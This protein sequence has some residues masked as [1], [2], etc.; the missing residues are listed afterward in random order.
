MNRNFFLLWQGQF[1]SSLGGHVNTIA[2]VA[3]VKHGT[4]SASLIG[5][6]MM[7]SSITRVMLSGIGGVFVDRHSR[8]RII[9]YSDMLRGIAVLSLA[10]LLY[11]APH[12]TGTIVIWLWGVA[13]CIA[14]T[15]AFFAPAMSAAIPELV[16]QDKVARANSLR[17]LTVQIST[18]VGQSLGGILFRL[19]GAPLL[20]L[21]NGLSFLYSAVSESFVTI[22][23][24]IP[25]ENGK[26]KEQVSIY[27]QEIIKGSLYIWNISALKRLLFVSAIINIFS[28]PIIILLPFY[29]EDYLKVKL[30]WYGFFLAIHSVGSVMG[31]LSAGF[32]KLKGE[33]RM[34]IMLT[35]MI[36][37]SLVIAL[38]GF[39]HSPIVA[40]VFAF[41]L[42]I[43]SGFNSTNIV[44][45]LQISTPSEMRGRIFGF[46]NT[47]SGST[48]PLGMG[49]GGIV[50]DL[51]G[52]NIPLVYGS[53]GGI[54]VVLSILVS[55]NQEFRGFLAY[56]PIQEKA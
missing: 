13:I 39:T 22:P 30:D 26:W 17:Q 10:G 8:R 1:V 7:V 54:M 35:F 24:T 28:A 44:T 32:I 36:F 25:D 23:Q 3:L 5:L 46:L 37:N 11:M 14:V 16:P 34:E 45:I 53:C 51:T 40:L 19:L 52:Q 55:M 12:A 31:S 56:E 29:V 38:F 49:L 6:V 21:I 15:S 27:K 2:L 48:V 18:S 43:M 20:V 4:G 50:F 41:I 47:L 9:I 33:V 42:G